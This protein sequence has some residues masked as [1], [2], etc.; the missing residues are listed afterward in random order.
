MKSTKKVEENIKY[1]SASILP[2]LSFILQNTQHHYLHILSTH[3]TWGNVYV[4]YSNYPSQN[5]YIVISFT[6]LNTSGRRS[7]TLGCVFRELVGERTTVHASMSSVDNS[8]GCRGVI[9]SGNWNY[10][11]NKKYFKKCIYLTLNTNTNANISTLSI[12]VFFFDLLE[13][14]F[15]QYFL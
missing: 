4:S 15:K 6:Y 8:T 3:K 7:I 9:S 2:P 5:E 11:N 10:T 1:L 14:R 13:I 12:F